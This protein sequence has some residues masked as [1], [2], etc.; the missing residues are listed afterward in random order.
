MSQAILP[1]ADITARFA[2][3][4]Q[5][6]GNT[7]LLA[8]EYRFRGARRV[9]YAKAENLNM[10][11]SIKDRMALHILRRGYERGAL[12]PGGPIIEATSGNT[13]ISFA[14]LGRALGHRVNIFMP[15]WMS[16]ERINLIRS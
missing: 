3:I 11:G 10:T 9:L 13:G 7:P 4:R 1:S 6:I 8:I 15:D 5:M 12:V 14:A 16:R 2:Q